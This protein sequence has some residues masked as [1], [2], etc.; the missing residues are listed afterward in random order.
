VDQGPGAGLAALGRRETLLGR[1][2][3]VAAG[4]GA[5]GLRPVRPRGPRQGERWKG[6]IFTVEM[7]LYYG[8]LD[9]L[10]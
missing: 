10:G 5:G 9:D 6:Q 7:V 4:E 1:S 2:L 3:A 8:I